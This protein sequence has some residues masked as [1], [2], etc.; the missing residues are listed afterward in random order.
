MICLVSKKLS[1]NIMLRLL[2]IKSTQL[3]RSL[4]SFCKEN[5]MLHI[6]I[7]LRVTDIPVRQSW[8][9]WVKVIRPEGKK[10]G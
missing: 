9:S 4:C 7:C 6:V 3:I 1:S 5:P 2:T 8:V 10:K